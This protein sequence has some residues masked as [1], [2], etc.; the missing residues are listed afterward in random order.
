MLTINMC[1][2]YVLL[3]LLIFMHTNDTIFSNQKTWGRYFCMW[4]SVLSGRK[5]FVCFVMV[6]IEPTFLLRPKSSKTDSVHQS[7]GQNLPCTLDRVN[8]A[9]PGQISCFKTHIGT[10]IM[11]LENSLYCSDKIIVRKFYSHTLDNDEV[12]FG[13]M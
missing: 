11:I 8:K 1:C 9:S 3:S 10:S 6:C 5:Y 7:L 2:Q 4:R 12:T 13:E